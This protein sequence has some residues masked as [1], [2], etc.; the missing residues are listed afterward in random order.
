MKSYETQ[1]NISVI[2]DGYPIFDGYYPIKAE[3]EVLEKMTKY[4]QVRKFPHKKDPDIKDGQWW[5]V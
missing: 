3:S 2:F 5:R 1:I 4:R